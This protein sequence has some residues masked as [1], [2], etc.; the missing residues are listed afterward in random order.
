MKYSNAIAAERSHKRIDRFDIILE[1]RRWKKKTHRKFS[2]SL[3]SNGP[4]VES[5]EIG[6][7]LSL[8]L[9]IFYAKTFQRCFPQA[10]GGGG[11]RGFSAFRAAPVR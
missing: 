11:S 10:G 7:L 6:L 1:N 8:V 3:D 4:L 9:F 5:C 2:V